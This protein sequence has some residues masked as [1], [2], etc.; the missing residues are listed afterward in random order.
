M[1]QSTPSLLTTEQSNKDTENLDMMTAKEIVTVINKE[2]H[3]VIEGVEK[4]LPAIVQ[5]ADAIADSLEKGGRLFIFGAGTSGRLGVMNA[6]G[7]TEKYH[8][9][10][11]QINGIIAGGDEALRFSVEN[12]EDNRDQAVADLM[13]FHPTADDVVLGIS[14]GGG[15]PYILQV[16]EEGRKLGMCT[17]GYSSNENAKLKSFSDIFINPVVGPEVLTGSSRMKSGSAQEMTLIVLLEASV[18]KTE[19]RSS[20]IQKIIK[21]FKKTSPAVKA[22]IPDITYAVKLIADSFNAGGRLFYFGKGTAGREGVLDASECWPTFGV[23]HGMVNGYVEG[24]NAALRQFFDYT[25][26]Q[27][28]NAAQNDFAQSKKL[29]NGTVRVGENP[30]DVVVGLGNNPYTL[31][32][33]KEAQKQKIKTVLFITSSDNKLDVSTDVCIHPIV[34]NIAAPVVTKFVLN[35]LTTASMALIGK[36]IGNKMVDVAVMNSKLVD[37]A[38]RIIA[39]FTGLAYEKSEQLLATAQLFQKEQNKDP[40]RHVVPIA[41]VMGKTGLCAKDADALLKKNKGLVRQALKQF[42]QKGKIK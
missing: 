2:D 12:S 20:T 32:A 29:P 35:T 28:V 13:S 17:I 38:T 31:T 33:L 6:V 11:G 7:I 10:P 3:K 16:L 4:V 14:A 24:G 37:R 18:A 42:S 22:C 36:V 19:D 26:E 27:S 9:K 8:L 34:D 39:D 41:I 5:G 40:N 15:A 21:S 30:N 25:T 23:E 1:Q